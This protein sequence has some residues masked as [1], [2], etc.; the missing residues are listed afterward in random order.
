VETEVKSAGGTAMVV[1]LRLQP[2]QLTHVQRL[3]DRSDEYGALVARIDAAR[4]AL[5]RRSE[6]RPET[7]VQRLRRALD[8]I[9]ATDFYPGRANVQA[10]DAMTAL[11]R[12]ARDLTASGEPRGERARVRKL[13]PAAYRGRTWATRKNPWIDR[14]AS[15]WII[16]RFIDHDARFVWIDSARECPKRAIGF[17]FDGA[18]F[19]HTADRVTFEVLVASFGLDRDPALTAIGAAVHCLDV[20]GIPV[21]DAK[22]LETVL[23][24]IRTQARSDDQK[25]RDASRIFDLFYAA[26]AERS[27]AATR[28]P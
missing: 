12:E 18:Q 15:A 25:V 21:A 14:L 16:K 6:G 28:L 8:D 17:D 11:E 24:G 9:A 27:A 22:G 10:L 2:S 23:A 4:S 7:T 5:K 19:T 26:Y 13:D 20:G 1:E 3:F